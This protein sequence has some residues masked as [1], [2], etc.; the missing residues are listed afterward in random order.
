MVKSTRGHSWKTRLAGEVQ[1]V[2]VSRTP[3][4]TTTD[5]LSALRGSNRVVRASPVASDPLS[6]S[7]LSN[8]GDQQPQKHWK[9]A[10]RSQVTAI[11]ATVVQSTSPAARLVNIDQ[12]RTNR[13]ETEADE[14]K[15]AEEWA[16]SLRSA[17]ARVGILSLAWNRQ[18][19]LRDLTRCLWRSVALSETEHV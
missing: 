15:R 2:S 17:S 11:E 16:S 6:P 1:A 19:D 14:L 7:N 4:T 8:A 9:K 10:L 12:Q 5:R 13:E 18:T 3:V